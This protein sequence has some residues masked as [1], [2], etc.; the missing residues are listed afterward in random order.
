MKAFAHHHKFNPTGGGWDEINILFNV[1]MDFQALT[2]E[3][4]LRSFHQ[5]NASSRSKWRSNW[6]CPET[7]S[8]RNVSPVS[9]REKIAGEWQDQGPILQKCKISIQWETRRNA[10]KFTWCICFFKGKHYRYG[11][12]YAMHACFQNCKARK[13]PKLLFFFPNLQWVRIWIFSQSW[14]KRHPALWIISC[15]QFAWRDRNVRV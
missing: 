12:R 14:K 8:A 3:D 13:Q 10:T 4:L 5:K 6:I 7:R 11:S 15:L 2:Q 1:W 9:N